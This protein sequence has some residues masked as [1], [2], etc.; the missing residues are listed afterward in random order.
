LVLLVL[1]LLVLLGIGI[2]SLG[3]SA[4]GPKVAPQPESV[5][6]HTVLVLAKEQV[7]ATLEQAQI[8]QLGG[9]RFIVGK[10]VKGSPYTKDTF[11]GGTVWIP[12]DDVTQL[13]ELPDLKRGK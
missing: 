4:E 13:V 3:R 2:A 7:A 8:R 1:G 6:K 9:R 10:V 11:S 5:S 12:V